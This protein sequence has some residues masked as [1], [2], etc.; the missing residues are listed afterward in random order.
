MLEHRVVLRNGV[1]QSFGFCI[2]VESRDGRCDV[3]VACRCGVPASRDGGVERFSLLIELGKL[4]VDGFS[5][6]TQ[7]GHPAFDVRN[8]VLRILGMPCCS[9]V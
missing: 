9:G 2:C 7:L 8:G 1:D 5:L 3:G 6:S 4:S